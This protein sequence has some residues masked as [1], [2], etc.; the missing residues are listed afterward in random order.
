MMG[1][2]VEE[3][4]DTVTI[5]PEPGLH[6]VHNLHPFV[7]HEL[8]SWSTAVVRASALRGVMSVPVWREAPR[9]EKNHG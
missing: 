9:N 7:M 5:L 2:P 8:H 1:L 6:A 4:E 3:L